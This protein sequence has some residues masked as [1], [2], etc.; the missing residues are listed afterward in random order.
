MTDEPTRYYPRFSEAKDHDKILAFY[1]SNTHKNVLKRDPE[2][3]RKMIEGGDVVFIEDEAG[4]IVAGSIT[5]PFAVKNAE[6]K[7]DIKWHEIGTLRSALHGFGVLPT[8]VPMQTLRTFIIDPPSDRFIAQMET[9]PVQNLAK[10]LGFRQFQPLQ[11]IFNQKAAT[12]PDYDKLPGHDGDWYQGGIEFIPVMARALVKLIENPII[13][14]PKTGDKIV[15]DFSRSSFMK[16]MEPLI[17]KLATANLGDV[18]KPD[19]AKSTKQQQEQVLRN[20]FH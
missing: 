5:W 4:N 3:M 15:L 14:N 10:S 19:F 8:L 13:E 12:V 18:D 11:E 16:I 17:R 1:D 6:G 7:E 20:I 9:K 2:A